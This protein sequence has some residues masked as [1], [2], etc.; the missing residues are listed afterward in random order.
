MPGLGMCGTIYLHGTDMKVT[1]VAHYSTL[2]DK[3]TYNNYGECIER[4]ANSTKDMQ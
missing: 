3:Y 2:Q 1:S 4:T